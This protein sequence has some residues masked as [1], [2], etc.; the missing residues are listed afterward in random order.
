MKNDLSNCERNLSNCVKSLKKIQDFN[1]IWA[2]HLKFHMN[3]SFPG[4]LLAPRPEREDPWN[5]V[6]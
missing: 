4:L 3:T 5:E 1:E 6:S 2:N